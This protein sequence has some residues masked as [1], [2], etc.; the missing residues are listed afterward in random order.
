MSVWRPDRFASYS[1]MYSVPYGVISDSSPSL[2]SY[3]NLPNVQ[4]LHHRPP[5]RPLLLL[6]LITSPLDSSSILFPLLR[7]PIA[8]VQ[9]PLPEPRLGTST[10]FCYEVPVRGEEK[11]P[12]GAAIDGQA[13]V[14]SPGRCLQLSVLGWA[15]AACVLQ[16]RRH[17]CSLT[18]RPTRPAWFNQ[19]LL[20]TWLNPSCKHVLTMARPCRTLYPS[21]IVTPDAI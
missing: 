4:P 8:S 5:A 10:L 15:M 3:Q 16:G 7:Q 19:T 12:G 2:V 21:L 6:L 14:A 18:L 1:E 17:C 13:S 9:S 11:A 20:Q